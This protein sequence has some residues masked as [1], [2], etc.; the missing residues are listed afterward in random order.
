[1]LSV[2][3]KEIKMYVIDNILTDNEY[4]MICKV[5]DTEI[6]AVLQRINVFKKNYGSIAY[7]CNGYKT[8]SLRYMVLFNLKQKIEFKAKY[9]EGG[10]I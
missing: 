6:E 3:R 10:L 7:Y 1:M 2:I 8:L 5:L 4:L 9:K